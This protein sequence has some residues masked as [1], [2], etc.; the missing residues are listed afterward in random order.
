MLF[1]LCILQL[2]SK[3]YY[4]TLTLGFLL[5]F[6]FRS[7]G[8]WSNQR[9]GGSGRVFRRRLRLAGG[10]KATS[11]ELHEGIIQNSSRGC[12]TA[13]S[14]ICIGEVDIRLEGD[15]VVHIGL[16]AD[17]QTSLR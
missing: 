15:T 4:I 14:G 17:G 7:F 9:R 11:E 2:V 6:E 10:R 1:N 13:V 16:T 5:A 8:E 12:A 3:V